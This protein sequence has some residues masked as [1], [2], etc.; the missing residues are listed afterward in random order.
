LFSKFLQYLSQLPTLLPTPPRSD[1][2][3][4]PK[5]VEM[6]DRKRYYNHVT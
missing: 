3:S 5:V 6:L 2:M 4:Q 1:Y